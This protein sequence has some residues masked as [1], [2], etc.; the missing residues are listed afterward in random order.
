M[1]TRYMNYAAALFALL[2]LLTSCASGGNATAEGEAVSET[3]AVRL[4]ETANLMETVQQMEAAFRD[5]SASTLFDAESALLRAERSESGVRVS[6]HWGEA[7]WTAYF[8]VYAESGQM[9]GAA[10]APDGV[11]EWETEIACDANQ[12]STAKMFRL[13]TEARPVLPAIAVSVEAGEAELALTLT[14]NSQA[15]TVEWEDNASVTALRELVKQSPVTIQ[16]SPYGGF[17]QV[18]SLGASLPREDAQT[19]TDAGDIVLYQGNQIVIFYGS[20]SWAYTRLGHIENMSR[21]ELRNLLGGDSVTA[22]FSLS[23]ANA[24]PVVYMTRDVSPTGLLRAYQALNWEPTGKTAVKLSTGEPPNSNYLRPELIKDL[25]QL[26]NGTIVECNTA[27]GGSRASSAMHKQVAA[28]HGFTAIADFD[29]MDEDGEKEIPVTDGVRL[30]RAIVGKHIDD[31][32]SFLI[33]SHFKG[34]AMAGFGGAIKNVAIGMS[35]AS[36]KVLVHTAGERTT[37]GIFYRNQDAWL[38]A[39]PEMVAGVRDYVGAENIVYV[40][41]MNRLSVDCDCDGNPSEPDMRDI[42]ILASYDPVALDQACVDLV[43]AAA[44]GASLIAR[45]ERQHGIRALEHGEEIGLGNRD[46]HLIS[47]D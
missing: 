25:V 35:S 39:L 26:V 2:L 44:D 45:M 31:Y 9:L 46:Y 3:G 28:D 32:D 30:N 8:A 19:T 40:N 22:V 1:K 13:D 27:Y 36:G 11:T 42:G 15:L 12:A 33:L 5:N 6:A 17:E 16:M 47:V 34:H 41:V 29:L 7:A 14:V 38:E 23:V 24:A 18:G 10:V 37:G 21:E 43:Y 4:T 20:N